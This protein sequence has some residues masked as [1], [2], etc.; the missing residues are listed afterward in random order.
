MMPRRSAV[1]HRENGDL[2]PLCSIN[3][4]RQGDPMRAACADVVITGLPAGHC[5]PLEC[6]A[7]HIEVIRH[8][9]QSK[10]L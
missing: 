6:K 7:A 10:N 3:G 9:L 2:D 5:L 4:N 1:R 8:W